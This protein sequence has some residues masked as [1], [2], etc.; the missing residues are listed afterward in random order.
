MA[1]RRETAFLAR[2]TYRRR[3]LIDAMRL[4]PVLGLFFFMLPILGSGSGERSTSA[5]GI[6]L[7]AIWLVLIVASAVLTR[8]L[9]RGDQGADSD[10]REPGG[11]EPL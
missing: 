2:N 11:G 7:F 3:R 6:Y 9:T 10:S 1:G 5:G 4:V 8:L